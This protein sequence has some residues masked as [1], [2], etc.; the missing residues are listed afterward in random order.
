M[1]GPTRLWGYFPANVLVGSTM[2]RHLGGIIIAEKGKPIE[3]T[4]R[5][6]LTANQK[7]FGPPLQSIIPVDTTIPGANQAQNRVAVHLHGGFIPW[8][9][10]GGPFDWWTPDG[11]HGLSFLNNA[12][13][14]PGAKP[15]EAE[16]Y[17][18]NE[19]TARLMWY[20][21]HA[22]GTTRINAYNGV[23]TAYI[24]R[25]NFERGLMN[26]RA[27]TEPNW[28]RTASEVIA[29]TIADTELPIIIQDKIFVDAK[30][31]GMDPRLEG[32]CAARCA[33]YRKPLVSAY[34]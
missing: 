32:C 31:I 34:L 1:F 24:L 4:F 10:D 17:Y 27:T 13:L 3:I 7:P 18:N 12:V 6:L 30:T 11:T 9:S 8:I 19:Q 2:P 15:N 23:A 25:D 21:D 28:P 29:T 22:W 5:N 20:H 14:N 16:Y 26:L 33:I